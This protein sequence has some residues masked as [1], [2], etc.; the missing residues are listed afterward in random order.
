[1]AE[2]FSLIDDPWIACVRGGGTQELVSLR[3]IFSVVEA[4]E[5]PVVG[6]RGDSPAQD[7][8]VLRLLLAI[9]WRAHSEAIHRDQ[10]ED[11]EH[12]DWFE[13]QR[14]VARVG[15]ADS[16]VLDYLEEYRERFDLLHPQS[17]FMQVADLHTEKDTRLE[18]RR[19]VPEAEDEYFTM[20]AGAARGT[21]AFAEAARWLIHA[22]AYDYSGIKSGAV[23][24][25]RVKG[26]RGY[27]I[28]TGWTGSTG[29]T[30]IVGATLRETLALN[31]TP[32]CL[33]DEAGADRTVWERDP[34]TPAQRRPSA[35][36]VYPTGPAD[37]ATWQS[38][39]VRLFHDGERVT[40]VLVSNGDRI[41]EAGA[42]IMDDPMTPYRYSANKSKKGHDVYYPRPFDTDRTMWKS[43]EPLLVLEGDPGFTE[44]KRAPK[45]PQTLTQLAEL[46]AKGVIPE[47]ANIQIVSV[48]YG[49]QASSIAEVVAGSIE[50]PVRLLGEESRRQRRLLLD[51][52]QATMDAAIA[53]GSFAGQLATAAGGEYQFHSAPTDTLLARLEQPFS[54]WLAGLEEGKLHEHA[55]RWQRYVRGRVLTEAEVLLQ[56]L[57]PQALV[58]REKTDNGISRI[59]SAATVVRRLHKKLDDALPATARPK[60]TEG[61]E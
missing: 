11:Y 19:I 33:L 30:V 41:P 8:A 17:P 51:N 24:D 3:R 45:R 59:E 58:G 13:E 5:A 36:A 60:A 29:G 57:S 31:T 7:Y 12:A 55:E 61:E 40:E 26:G 20:R 46:R 56:G 21:L 32:D 50:I 15:E 18:A 43:L 48:A 25:P 38:R 27:P 52:A 14:E 44:K 22:Q 39:R 49:P 16:T 6:L 53:L 47:W 10:G 37:L 4:G 54:R 9:Y 34:D 23:G 1:M 42:N 28:G 2:S 35:E